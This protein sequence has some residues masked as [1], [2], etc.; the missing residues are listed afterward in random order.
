MAMKRIQ[1]LL[2]VVVLGFTFLTGTASAETKGVF[3]D[4]SSADIFKI[5]RAFAVG[6]MLRK[7]E[8]IPVTV[9]ISL[10][11]TPYAKKDYPV[12]KMLTLRDQSVHQHMEDF[13]KTG[14]EIMVCS[15]CLGGHG[16]TVADL[17]P[18]MTAGMP[19]K[20]IVADDVKLLSY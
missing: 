5:H 14:G 19:S 7:M 17:L 11:V 16:M 4:L 13:M 20:L 6:T 8:K 1:Q 3:I 15:M 10:G 18:G 12:A 2:L 9:F